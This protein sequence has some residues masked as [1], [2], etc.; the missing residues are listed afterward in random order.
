MALPTIGVDLGGTKALLLCGEH[1]ERSETGPDL[2]PAALEQR[3]RAFASRLEAPPTGIGLAVPGLVDLD[4]RITACDVLPKFA[5]WSPK[6]ALADLGARVVVANDVKAALAEEMHDLSPGATAGV[7]MAGTAIGAAFVTEGRTLLGASGWA[8]ELGYLPIFVDG[9]V[10]RLDELAGG[11]F[12]AASVGMSSEELARRAAAGD[13]SIL[14]TIGKGGF[15]LG[16]GLAAVIN[17]LNPSRLAVGGGALGLPGYWD[18]AR[19]AAARHSI[20]EM[21]EACRLYQ[22]RTGARVAALGAIRLA[23]A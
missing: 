19:D 2:E 16:L 9:G 11:S 22:V 10:K 15:A 21:F 14:E 12:T 17:L 13:A 4:G 7:V 18:A 23:S 6:D 5:G 20:P 1:E 3:L 8:G